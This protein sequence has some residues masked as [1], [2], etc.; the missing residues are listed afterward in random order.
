MFVFLKR[1]AFIYSALFIIC[2]FFIIKDICLSIDTDF[3]WHLRMGRVILSNGISVNDSFS[4]TMPTYHFIDHEWLSDIFIAVLYPTLGLIG[5][6][7]LCTFIAYGSLLLQLLTI[8]K[9]WLAVPLFLCMGGFLDYLGI[10]PQIFSWFFFSVLILILRNE[11]RWNSLR[12]FVPLLFLLWANVHG[13]FVLGFIVLII[14]VLY[15]LY[16]QREVS[17]IDAGVVFASILITLCNPYGYALWWETWITFTSSSLR[18]SIHE[19]QP[20]FFSLNFGL[21]FLLPISAFFVFK[22]KKYLLTR[23]LVLFTLLL[24]LGLSSVKNIPYFLILAL[25]MTIQ[26]ITYFE[27][28]I[29]KIPRARERFSKAY[30]FYF[31][32]VLVGVLWQIF[33]SSII[34]AKYHEYS[35]YPIHAVKYLQKHPFVGELFAEYDWGG[36]LIWKYPEKKVFVD[37]RMPT[38]SLVNPSPNESSNA[39]KEYAAFFKGKIPFSQFA[40]KYHITTILL[41]NTKQYEGSL[42]LSEQMK[43]AGFMVVYKDTV[44][45]IYQKRSQ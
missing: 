24:V 16:A 27:Q 38:W 30:L 11:K 32:F 8:G 17:F 45:V 22:T 6:S 3:G 2:L 14:S 18:A 7:I 13:S 10:R 42:H 40:N 21:V 25:P 15:K 33:F 39:F 36:Y 19:W 34:Y 28:D 1:W 5:L 43:K 4:Y 37:G 9:K 26:A 12:F 44:A 31:V 23:D 41:K 35:F 20:A 29:R